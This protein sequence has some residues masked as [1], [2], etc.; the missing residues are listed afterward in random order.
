MLQSISEQKV[1]LAAEYSDIL[2][3]SAHQLSIIEKIISVLKPIEDTTQ[4]ISSDKA[5]V[6]L[7]IPFIRALRKSWESNEDD[8]GIR[9]MKEEMLSSLN[10]RYST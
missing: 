1:A 6:S 8:L 7:I 9:T 2:Q 5:S 3:L 4:S 10:R